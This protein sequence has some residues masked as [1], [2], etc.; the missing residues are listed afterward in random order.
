MVRTSGWCEILVEV[1]I[2]EWRDGNAFP[3]VVRTLILDGTSVSV[4]EIVEDIIVSAYPT[5]TNCPLTITSTQQLLTVAVVD[6][7]GRVLL[8]ERGESSNSKAIDLSHLP[9]GIY[10]VH[11]ETEEGRWAQRVVRE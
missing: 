2:T 1:S 6:M 4:G 7:L 8:S 9:A 11:V 5:T 10:V 3:S